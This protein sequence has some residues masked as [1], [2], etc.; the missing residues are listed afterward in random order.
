MEHVE[1]SMLIITAQ[2]W[3]LGIL[4]V[5]VGLVVMFLTYGCKRWVARCVRVRFVGFG[6]SFIHMYIEQHIIHEHPRSLTTKA[7]ASSL[8]AACV[9]RMHITC[10]SEIQL[11][12]SIGLTRDSLSHLPGSGL[13]LSGVLEIPTIRVQVPQHQTDDANIEAPPALYLSSSDP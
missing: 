7:P 6:S 9:A 1:G 5:L 11:V 10:S 12:S 3:P 13:I 8:L 2:G 4:Q